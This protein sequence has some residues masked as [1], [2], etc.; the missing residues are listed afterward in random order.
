MV[1][2]DTDLKSFIHTKYEQ[3]F[4]DWTTTFM[5]PSYLFGVKSKWNLMMFVGNSVY[6]NSDHCIYF[7][8][9]QYP[10]D[11]EFDGDGYKKLSNDLCRE[12]IANGFNLIKNGSYPYGKK[13]GRKFSCSRCSKYRGD[14]TTRASLTY[15][16]V[17]YHC[18][19]KNFRGK[20]GLSMPRRSKTM[21]SLCKENCCS[22]FS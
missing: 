21:R 15:Q 10:I 1:E 8:P 16:R 7:C 2:D 11:G 3:L 18:D 4:S 14:T 5:F 13:S 22:F 17:T 20:D 19:R 9:D 6:R 12:S